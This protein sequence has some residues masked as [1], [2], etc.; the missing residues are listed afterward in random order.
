[1]ENITTQKV[2]DLEIPAREWL[3]RLFG[4]SLQEEEEV[5]ILVFPQHA[6]PLA[7]QRQAAVQRMDRVL[8]KAAEQ[9]KDVPN[10]E[11]DDAVDEAM[12]H[13]RKRDS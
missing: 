9:M 2:G 1:M 4:R 7:D 8:D 12:K 10:S 6:A 13:V 11:Y 3:H 5:T